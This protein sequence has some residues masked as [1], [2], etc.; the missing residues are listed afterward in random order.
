MAWASIELLAEL[1]S[2]VEKAISS[3]NLICKDVFIGDFEQI[4]KP[5][6]TP[7]CVISPQ[8]ITVGAEFIRHGVKD[9]IDVSIV[10]IHPKLSIN[11]NKL[12]KSSDSTGVLF[13]LAIL[14]N[15]LEKKVSDGTINLNVNST[16]GEL[17]KPQIS[18][19][20]SQSEVIRAIVS[21]RTK[22]KT[23]QRGAR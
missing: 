15:Y 17:P 10:Y 2:R 13:Q 18:F 3:G 5:N 23:Y 7:I 11:D 1:K 9:E 22:T 6:D 8:S 12:Y 16:V 14:L 4:R 20:Y 21:Y 19:D